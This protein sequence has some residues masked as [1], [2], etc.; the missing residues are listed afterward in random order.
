[1]YIKF[2]NFPLS[3]YRSCQYRRTMWIFEFSQVFR[4]NRRNLCQLPRDN[5]TKL[6]AMCWTSALCNYNWHLNVTWFIS[7]TNSRVAQ[8]SRW[9]F[10]ITLRDCWQNY[11]PLCCTWCVLSD[12]K[13]KFVNVRRI[14]AEE[15]LLIT[16]NWNP[17]THIRNL[18]ITQ[19][20]DI[21]L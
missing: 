2:I 10:V 13:I 12:I 21:L 20:C 7:T 6:R 19:L 8:Q 16:L 3:I 1:M 18:Q 9:L 4:P 5:W 11:R 14:N 15:M 17:K